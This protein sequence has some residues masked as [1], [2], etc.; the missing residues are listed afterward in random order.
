MWHFKQSFAGFTLQMVRL[1]V[2]E[3]DSRF[4]APSGP[5]RTWRWQLKHLA[6]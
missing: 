2:A 6:S 1:A 3:P 4:A 5:V